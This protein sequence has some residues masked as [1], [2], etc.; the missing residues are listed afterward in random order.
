M[1]PLYRIVRAMSADLGRL[2]REGCMC[3]AGCK[4]G[5]VVG[6]RAERTR[7]GVPMAKPA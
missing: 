7:E 5:L 1:G 2:H 4:P 3:E 6:E